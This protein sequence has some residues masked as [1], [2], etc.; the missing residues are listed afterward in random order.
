MQLIKCSTRPEALLIFIIPVTPIQVPLI[1]W[2][3]LIS[4]GRCCPWLV[5]AKMIKTTY[6][7]MSIHILSRM[8]YNFCFTNLSPGHASAPTPATGQ[9]KSSTR[10]ANR[11]CKNKTAKNNTIKEAANNPNA[12][13]TISIAYLQFI[14]QKIAGLKK[15]AQRNI[16]C[17]RQSES[18]SNYQRISKRSNLKDK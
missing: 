17:W 14:Q 2:S 12:A 10:G 9:P 6:I 11:H 5:K 1:F 15:A 8:S 18:E 7:T 13:V 3:A 4:H 16:C